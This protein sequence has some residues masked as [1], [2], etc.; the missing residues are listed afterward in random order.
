M[1]TDARVMSID[2]ALFMLAVGDKSRGSYRS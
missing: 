2:E 1:M